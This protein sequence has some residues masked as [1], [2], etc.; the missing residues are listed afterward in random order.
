[1]PISLSC[2]G[3]LPRNAPAAAEAIQLRNLERLYE[4]REAV[5]NLIH[6]LEHYQRT[7][8][9]R[10]GFSRIGAERRGRSNSTWDERQGYTSI[11]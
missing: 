3:C 2:P 7:K 8:T 10:A 4:R 5:T 1:M 9:S 11:A 6:S